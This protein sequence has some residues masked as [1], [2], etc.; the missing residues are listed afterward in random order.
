[1]YSFCRPLHNVSQDKVSACINQPMTVYMSFVSYVINQVLSIWNCKCKS[2]LVLSL[3][4]LLF[5]KLLSS[6]NFH[7]KYIQRQPWIKRKANLVRKRLKTIV[8][9]KEVLNLLRSAKPV[10]SLKFLERFTMNKS[11]FTWFYG[12]I[13]AW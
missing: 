5:Y 10:N 8:L 1:M 9:L 13:I 12:Q 3:L 2:V 7:F 11:F 6:N 4:S